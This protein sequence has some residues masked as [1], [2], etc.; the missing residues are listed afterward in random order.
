MEDEPRNCPECGWLNGQCDCDGEPPVRSSEMVG[1][2]VEP[3]M[4]RRCWRTVT[5]DGCEYIAEFDDQQTTALR[6]TLIHPDGRTEQ[7]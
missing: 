3:P 5:T 4:P 1:R 2:L 6:N 7:W